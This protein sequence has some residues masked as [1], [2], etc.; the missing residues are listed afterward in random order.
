MV[1]LAKMV[2]LGKMVGLAKEPLHYVWLA[3]FLGPAHLFVA[4][5]TALHVQ[6]TK[7]WAGPGNEANVRQLGLV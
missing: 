5:S 3:S 1:G 4:C 6:G 7:S 2:G